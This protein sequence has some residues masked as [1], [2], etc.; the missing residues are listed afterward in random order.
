[1]RATEAL[2]AGT[3]WVNTPLTREI[4]APFGGFKHSGVGRDGGDWSRALFTEEKTI[5]IPTREFPIA[6]LGM[7]GK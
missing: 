5:T 4:R 1:M 2:R 3:I 6:K 7:Q